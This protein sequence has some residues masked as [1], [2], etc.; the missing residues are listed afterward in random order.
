MRQSGVIA[1]AGLYALDHHVDRLADDH[2]APGGSP[3]ASP[4]WPAS[5][6]TR[7][8]R[9]QHRR[10]RGPRRRCVLLGARGTRRGHGPLAARV[11][12]AVTHLDV[13]A[14]GIDRALAVRRPRWC[15]LRGWRSLFGTCPLLRGHVRARGHV[16]DGAVT[17]VRGDEQGRVRPRASSAPRACRCKRLHDDPDR[18]RAPM[19][20][21][22]DGSSATR[23][24]RKPLP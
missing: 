2:G 16:E 23:R 6:S 12:R 11:V 21:E 24:G 17:G 3:R 18:L 8:G 7:H 5:R 13:D 4:H 19:V 1:A 10:L 22:D 20:R 9:D 15:R 14:A